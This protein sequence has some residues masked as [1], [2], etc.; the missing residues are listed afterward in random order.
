MFEWSKAG[1]AGFDKLKECL[2]SEPVYY[3]FDSNLLN[4]LWINASDFSGGGSLVWSTDHRK[5][6]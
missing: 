2:C 5:A 4:E 1:Q 3:L 6:W